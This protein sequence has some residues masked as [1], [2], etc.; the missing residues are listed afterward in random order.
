[1]FSH[2][3]PPSLTGVPYGR[4]EQGWGAGGFAEILLFTS[5]REEAFSETPIHLA[6][7]SSARQAM[8]GP[9]NLSGVKADHNT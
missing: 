6:A 4:G 2:Q 5:R 7:Y 1:M 9:E 8:G 3:A